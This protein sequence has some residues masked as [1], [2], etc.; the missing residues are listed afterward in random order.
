LSAH[1]LRPSEPIAELSPT[2]R[3]EVGTRLRGAV[4]CRITGDHPFVRL[5]V[6]QHPTQLRLQGRLSQPPEHTAQRA[7]IG[8]LGQFQNRTHRIG[9]QQ[10]LLHVTVTGV[11]I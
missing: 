2:P 10:P 9:R 11:H 1:R 6:G 8:H 7:V 4:A 3:L 5:K